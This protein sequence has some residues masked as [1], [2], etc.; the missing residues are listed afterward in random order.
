MLVELPRHR[1]CGVPPIT[2][3]SSK[4]V[5]WVDQE[6]PARQRHSTEEVLGVNHPA[7]RQ[8]V[9]RRTPVVPLSWLRTTLPGVGVS[10][11]MSVLSSGLD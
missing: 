11:P 5:L 7:I 3:P 4:L 10:T 8:G 6:N 9:L 1:A 2:D